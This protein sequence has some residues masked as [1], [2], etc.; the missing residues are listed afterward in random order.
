MELT[1]IARR[2]LIGQVIGLTF[3]ACLSRAT[4]AEMPAG[5]L[6]KEIG[7]WVRIGA[8]GVISLAVPTAEMGQGSRTA[9]AMILAEELDADWKDVKTFEP[10]PDAA[11]YGN[12]QLGGI[13]LTV[14]SRAVSG[15]WDKL[16]LQGA[17]IRRVLMQAA[18]DAWR[19][20]AAEVTTEPSAVLHTKSERKLTYREIAAFA[21]V[22][23]IIPVAGK[24]DLKKSSDYRIVGKSVARLD[25]H[26]KTTGAALYAID[27]QIPG[28]VYATVLRGPVEGSRPLAV[29]D[30]AAR[31]IRGVT[32]ITTL[33]KAVGVVGESVEAVFEARRAIRVT[34]S[35]NPTTAYNSDAGLQ[36][37]RARA[38]DQSDHGATYLAVGDADSAFHSASTI[39]SANYSSDYIYHAQMEPMNITVAVGADGDSAEIWAGTQ[40]PTAMVMSAAGLLKTRPEKIK[41]NLCYLGG[42]FGRRSTADHLPEAIELAKLV[43]RPAKLI[44]PREQDVQ[45]AKLRPMTAH[46]LEAAYDSDGSL[47]AWRHRIVG[48]SIQAY[49]LGEA[50]LAEARGIDV[51][52]VEGAKHSY[53][54]ANQSITYHR[55]KRGMGLSAWRAIGA[56]YNKFAVECFIDELAASQKTDP[57]EFRLK[58]LASDL[59]S[60]A[61]IRE[62]ARR[63]NWSGTSPEGH[64]LGFACGRIVESYIAMA[65]DISIDR[66]TGK[67]R[68][69]R[70]WVSIDP[71]IAV[72][73]D[74]VLAQ[75]EGNIIFGLSQALKEQITVNGG[76]VMQSNFHDYQVLRMEDIPE[77]DI[78]IVQTD[79]PPTGVGE[80]ALPLVAPCIGN[81]F[82]RLTGKRLRELPLSPARVKASLAA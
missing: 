75:T 7:A 61:V 72:N 28:M 53:D 26:A 31:A 41:L 22:P 56:G 46:R 8:D 52:L 79:N 66:N 24:S 25:V 62:T 55:E 21:E 29:D 32:L 23:A 37:F 27:V 9:L 5:E 48:E 35:A 78:Q 70:V 73:P 1:V 49:R 69:H 10:P 15:Y 64:A 60:T 3:T 44:W 47:F 65:C 36:E 51:L 11:I 45:S 38:A 54:I 14:G 80:A 71:G 17:A 34:W 67:I 76:R 57:V 43:K 59:R 40:G 50:A 39:V 74:T 4:A 2:T 6:S 18:A 42:G 16:R 30:A 68:V 58:L 63:A 81:A 19:V 77:I 82:Y 20:P 13:L 33:A 12:P